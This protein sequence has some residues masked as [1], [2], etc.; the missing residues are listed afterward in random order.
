MTRAVEQELVE[1]TSLPWSLLQP[2]FRN[3]LLRTPVGATQMDERNAE[4]EVSKL[5]S[6]YLIIQGPPGTGKT[7]LGPYFKFSTST[8]KRSLVRVTS[9]TRIRGQSIVVM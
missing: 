3:F 7:C 1:L 8:G 9:L 2:S 5:H 4:E 6:N